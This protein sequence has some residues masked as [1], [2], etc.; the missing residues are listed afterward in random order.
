MIIPTKDDGKQKGFAFINFKKTMYAIKAVKEMNGKQLSS[1]KYT[2]IIAVDFSMSKDK[3]INH[4]YGLKRID[5]LNQEEE[6]KNKDKQLNDN[7][8]KLESNN[9]ETDLN[10]NEELSSDDSSNESDNELDDNQN[11]K[12]QKLNDN[13]EIND[14]NDDN[15]KILKRKNKFLNDDNDQNKTKKHKKQS[16]D[17][18]EGKTIFIKNLSFETQQ[19]D[20]ADL[21]KQFGDLEYCIICMDKLTEHSKGTAFVKFKNKE[22][23]N[24]CIEKANNKDEESFYLDGRILDVQLAISKDKLNVKKL[25][26]EKVKDKRNLYLSKE[27]LIYP[28][29]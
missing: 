2:R 14:S 11:V 3:Y 26:N 20:L 5:V 25:E 29:R 24:K 19:D 13:D 1:N 28:G 12:E 17:I 21:F 10:E 7:N 4:M 18:E 9:N 15:K 22:D 6:E 8:I 23:A 27:G 16:N